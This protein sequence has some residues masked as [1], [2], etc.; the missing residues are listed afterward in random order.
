MTF[1]TI[2][3]GTFWQKFYFQKTLPIIDDVIILEHWCRKLLAVKNV[4]ILYATMLFLS[5]GRDDVL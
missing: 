1:P 3:L 5:S 2:S 4:N